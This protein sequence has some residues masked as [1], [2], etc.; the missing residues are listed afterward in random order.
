M[1][2]GIPE[3]HEILDVRQ[4]TPSVKAFVFEA[5]RIAELAKPGQFVMVWLPGVDE[6]PISVA[7]VNRKKGLV[8]LAISKAGDCTSR[9]HELGK[10]KTLGLRGPFGNGFQLSNNMKKI[11]MVAGGYGSAPLRF[12]A[13]QL[14]DEKR[15]ITVFLGARSKEHLLFLHKFEK[16]GCE[17]KVSTDDGSAGFKGFVTELVKDELKKSKPDIIFT[18]GPELMMRKVC[19]LA[20]KHD[21]PVQASVER[22]V[23]CAHGACGTCDIGGFRICKDG[24]VFDG[25]FLLE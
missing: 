6:I 5:K 3:L 19:E 21:V 17:V 20:V 7:H 8:E 13:E 4:E 18:C 11:W 25:R 22:I 24:P 16:L 14:M 23:K 15:K 12:L 10:G 9:I 1:S 2:T